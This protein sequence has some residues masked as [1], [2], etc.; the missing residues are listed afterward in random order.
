MEKHNKNKKKKYDAEAFFLSQ[1]SIDSS[2]H[3]P[4]RPKSSQ[5]TINKHDD[6][7]KLLE[8][9]NKSFKE[10]KGRC[11]TVKL[12]KT[13]SKSKENTK[14]IEYRRLSVTS[15]K[16]D[17]KSTNKSYY[18][19]KETH[20]LRKSGLREQA[21]P[22]LCVPPNKAFPREMKAI[23]KLIIA[24]KQMTQMKKSKDFSQSVF[25]NNK[26]SNSLEM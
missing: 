2:L 19:Q 3:I 22:F 16:A 21:R 8:R 1:M 10:K 13:R 23:N 18:P 6:T 12:P 25:V 9:F 24:E 20:H 14:G 11:R 4:K 7:K 26:M 15:L 17:L 5:S